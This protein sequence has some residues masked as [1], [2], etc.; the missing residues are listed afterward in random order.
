[1]SAG[2]KVR[3]VRQVAGQTEKCKCLQQEQGVGN[4]KNPAHSYLLQ[5]KIV[6]A[7]WPMWIQSR[8]RLRFIGV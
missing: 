1:M 6:K 7:G 3:E 5:C 4:V 2:S 8:F